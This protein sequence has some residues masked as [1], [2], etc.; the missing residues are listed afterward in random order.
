MP[1]PREIKWR[2]ELSVGAKNIWLGFPKCACVF[3]T[4]VALSE[5]ATYPTYLHSLT[6]TASLPSPSSLF[7]YSHIWACPG[8]SS[9]P[10]GLTHSPNIQGQVQ[11]FVLMPTNCVVSLSACIFLMVT[12]KLKIKQLSLRSNS[13]ALVAMWHWRSCLTSPC[14]HFLSWKKRNHDIIS[15]KC[16]VVPKTT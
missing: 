8:T 11:I 3:P 10:A 5:E 2:S 12:H 15:R 7:F 4:F 14:L 9:Q 16:K 13:M 1:P 6:D